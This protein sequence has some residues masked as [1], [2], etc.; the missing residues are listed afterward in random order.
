MEQEIDS[1]ARVLL[2]HCG[3]RGVFG[4]VVRDEASGEL[5]VV[6]ATRGDSARRFL[7]AIADLEEEGWPGKLLRRMAPP[8]DK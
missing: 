4:R 8:G 3:D 1:A 2:S 5:Q 7:D 6:Y